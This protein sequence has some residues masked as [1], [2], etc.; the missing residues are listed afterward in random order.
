MDEV[1]D[2][3]ILIT[4]CVYWIYMNAT[5]RLMS[6]VKFNMQHSHCARSRESPALFTRGLA[7]FLSSSELL[8]L[9]EKPSSLYTWSCCFSHWRTMC[10]CSNTWNLKKTS[11]M[12]TPR[13]SSLFV[14][15]QWWRCAILASAAA[16][17]S[18]WEEASRGRRG[19]QTCST[20]SDVK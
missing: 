4:R 15:S 9:G 12:K 2:F 7:L 8:C 16:E 14:A 19:D 20:E 3:L 10:H 6:E 13:S 11:R 1:Q 17:A 18:V 5:L